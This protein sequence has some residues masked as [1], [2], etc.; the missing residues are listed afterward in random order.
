MKHA[1]GRA[2]DFFNFTTNEH[3]IFETR[4]ELLR[5]YKL[6]SLAL[7]F[8][9]LLV[10]SLFLFLPVRVLDFFNT[11]SSYVGISSSPTG[12]IHFYL[13]LAVAFMYLVA[14]LALLMFRHPE[15][16]YF[17]LLLANGKM[18]SS[19][20]S[21]YLFLSQ[22]PY[23]IFLVNCVVDG[24]IGIAAFMFYRRIKH[25]SSWT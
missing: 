9:F 21:L 2:Q 1:L 11:L 8:I 17:P 25:I 20:L 24:V 14:V 6:I 19:M 23:L 4:E 15:N 10:G 3:E 16:S 22:H 13:V 18:A 5:L 12:S 7:F